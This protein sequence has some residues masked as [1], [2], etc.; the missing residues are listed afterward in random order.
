MY[1]SYPGT[2][3]KICDFGNCALSLNPNAEFKFRWDIVTYNSFD[4]FILAIDLLHSE[5]MIAEIQALE[6]P[7]L[8]KKHDHHTSCPIQT[9]AEKL[10]AKREC[11][12]IICSKITRSHRIFPKI[13]HRQIFHLLYVV[14]ILPH[15]DTVDELQGRP[16]PVELRALVDIDDSVG[17][18]FPVPDGVVQEAFDPGQDHFEDGETAA[19]S[20]TSQEV[21]LFCYLGL[22][23]IP[24]FVNVLNDL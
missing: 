10:S 22:F 12:Y 23:G 17:R 14:L 7:L 13:E 15:G 8:A 1:I 20:F 3:C 21:S 24:H 16:Q 19:E 5:D 9:L 6:S 2:G 4:I 18:R 11:I